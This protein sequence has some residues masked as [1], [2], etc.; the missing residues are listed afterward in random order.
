MPLESQTD[1]S[2]G[3]NDRLPP[4]KI[5]ANQCAALSN[6]DLSFGDLRGEYQTVSGG[7]KDYYYEKAGTWVSAAGFTETIPISTF[8]EDT[9]GSGGSVTATAISA[10]INYY[11]VMEIGDHET[12]TLGTD[13]DV[14]LYEETQGVHGASSFVEYNDDL[15][16][17]RDGTNFTV[18]GSWNH[19]E[20]SGANANRLTIATSGGVNE[21]YKL[22]VGDELTATNLPGDTFI[23][24][25]DSASKHVYINGFVSNTSSNQ[26]VS[27]A[28]IIS[29]F[30]DGDTTKSY[31][32]SALKPEPI[33]SFTQGADSYTGTNTD[34][35]A[36]HSVAWYSSNIAV[37]FQY[38]L[39]HFDK[40]GYESSMSPLTDSSLSASYFSTNN[41]IPMYIEFGTGV[42]RNSTVTDL[43][44]ASTKLD[45]GRFALYRV[46]G[47]SSVIKKLDNLFIDEDLTV[48]I[49]GT[50]SANLDIEI[51]SAD[52]SYHYRVAW[53]GF[54]T[55][56]ATQYSYTNGTY[57]VAATHTGKTDWLSGKSAY[58]GSDKITLTS[59]GT[60]TDT[61]HH[62]DLVVYM[63]IPGELVEREYVCRA[64]SVDNADVATANTYPYVDF[65]S[66]D[67]LIDI[68]PIQANN[69]PP[70][71][72]KFL[73]E[74]GN[75]FYAAVETRLYAS[76]YGN[77]NSFRSGAFVDF[78]Q[79]I[80]GLSSIGSELVVFTQY[81]V[82]RVYGSDPFGLKKVRVPTTEG[83]PD[84]GD[85]TIVKF[86]GGIMFASHQGI[87]FY[88]GKSVERLTHNILESF[89]Y[90]NNST[91]SS[92]AGGI[93]DDVYYLL[94]S[95][96]TGYKVDLKS[97]PL[98]VTRT[99]FNASN[100]YYRGAENILYADTGR[101]GYATGSRSN[102]S[103]TTRKF[104]AGDIN[105]EK[106][107]K[108][109]R[110]TGES[111]YG[112]VKVLVDGTETDSFSVGGSVAD[113][114]RTFYLT[115]P[116]QGNGIQVQLVNC[117]GTVHRINIDYEL[118]NEITERLYESVQVQ[119][120][121][122]PSITV[123][124][125]GTDLIG[126]G[127]PTSLSSHSGP[128]GEA[129]LYFPEMSTGLVPHIKETTSESAGRILSYQY[130]ASPV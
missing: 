91:K 75:I 24:R 21:A 122:T 81:G 2:G 20:S 108:S 113:F 86:Q 84:G 121:G 43:S 22:Q 8:T 23:T 124:L 34:R 71:S 32:V 68:Q 89:T 39:A 116:R 76:D 125:D 15:Y 111:F 12:V 52:P 120:T 85:K 80:T 96:G 44:H 53:Y 48:A 92:N 128:V 13:V 106:V 64:L 47:S 105:Y 127:T 58:T 129:V 4:H 1:F 82:Y 110:L 104:S 130:K 37:P 55:A 70:N 93:F 100:L 95:S 16:V 42:A 101:P 119:Y 41:N 49:S 62:V 10:D 33:I 99:T 112:T 90:P 73:I 38:G 45:G 61:V 79:K 102:F 40:T 72:S 59:D 9:S 57:S 56:T 69:K 35:N 74:S 18:N 6:A 50:G 5:G 78:D 26:T 94:G 98:K 67:S 114:D 118:T 7:Q 83:V 109:V 63:K 11:S 65:Q 97:S 19:T 36:G 123:S 14:E 3:V 51:G 115:Q 30:L 25:V 107:Y 54:L 126:E 28:P 60:G 66:S 87:C 117:Y 31:R 103:V 46:G 77:P 17:S 29:K 27:V 88:N